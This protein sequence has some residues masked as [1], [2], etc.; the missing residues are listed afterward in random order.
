MRLSRLSV[1]FSVA[2]LVMIA[3]NGSF[4]LLVA[5]SHRLLSQ[6]Q[7]HRQR[8]LTLVQGLREESQMLGRLVALYA[9]T[10]DPRFL[11]YYYDILGIR[12]GE[13]PALPH[14]S[15]MIYWGKVIAGEVEHGLPTDGTFQSLRDRMR[16][17]GLNS[18]EL[19]ALNA[20][21]AANESLKEL[22]QI[23]FAA[24]QGLYDPKAKSFVSDG[25]PDPAFALELINGQTYNKAWLRLSEAIESLLTLVDART[26]DELAHARARLQDWIWASSIGFLLMIVF[27]GF[28][29]R[30]IAT[31]VLRPV[32]GLRT[33]AG[34]L[35]EGH[36]DA[37]AGNLG[38]VEELRV[39]AA[40]LDDM[41]RAISADI[42]HREAVQ[43]ELE[44][45]R[46]KAE[47]ATLA[48]SRFLANMSHEI[49]TPM[50]A[51][52]GML[53][54][55]LGTQ[56]SGQ[57]RDYLT[58][59]Q[60][61]AKSLLGILNDVLD[62]SKVEADR[63]ELDL[64]PFQLEQIVGEALLLVQQR[65]QEKEVELLFDAGGLWLI[66]EG[67]ELV[68][69]ALR[70]R[71]ILANLLSNAVKFT[72]QGHVRL[73]LERRHEDAGQ[74]VIHFAVEDTGIGISDEQQ[75]R[76]FKEFTQA[77]GSTTRKYGGTGLGLV[78]SKRLVELMGGR[79]EVRSLPGRGSTF[80][81]EL[82]FKRPAATPTAA[83]LPPA[84]SSLRALVVDDYP[85]ARAVLT[86][87]LS[88]LSIQRIDQCSNGRC[89]VDH[90][91]DAWAKGT[92][93]D[94]LILDWL[95]PGMDGDA[96]LEALRAR[97]VPA[98]K[99]TIIVSAFDLSGIREHAQDLGAT[100][101]IGKP[102][103]PRALLD[104][105]KEGAKIE[106]R[107]THFSHADPSLDLQG[108]RVLLVEDNSLNQQLA[109]EL[110]RK[111]GVD[112]DVANN[113]AE[114]L[115]RLAMLPP[116]HYAL[117]LMDLQ[118]PVMDGYQATERLRAHPRY[119]HLPIVAM[120]AHAMSD[121]RERGLALGMQGYLAKPFEPEA[122]YAILAE[123]Q[124][125]GADAS[126][127]QAPP[128]PPDRA[129]QSDDLPHIP[130]LD[131]RQGL[132]HVGG[133]RS[134]Y[135]DLLRSFATQHRD[136][137]ARLDGDLDRRDWESMR[138]YV[139]TAKGLAGTLGMDAVAARA[140]ELERAAKAADLRTPTKLRDFIRALEPILRGLRALEPASP[141]APASVSASSGDAAEQIERIRAL[142]AEGDIEATDL[143]Q[144]HSGSIATLLP[145]ATMQR[146]SRAMERFDF[147]NALALLDSLDERT[148]GG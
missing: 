22:E 90:V 87:L 96:V 128:P 101:F 121:E 13:K 135:L 30:I 126:I 79:M 1:V 100:D 29:I 137:Q 67:G 72:D 98:P 35:A 10:G 115:D 71:Q 83:Q 48:K 119:E 44:A 73:V 140:L 45:A 9:N 141:A 132:M 125:A 62:F 3:I 123:Y 21:L 68:G 122:L 55:A 52:I 11:L 107:S 112:V 91:A 116:E 111:R 50:N 25:E 88:Q 80:A 38:G 70:L 4:T 81:F 63:L 117:V 54:L 37:R 113:G 139:H 143:W 57:Q 46:A 102:I 51:V 131:T 43:A 53:H 49:R 86:G 58:K 14:K 12:E 99:A 47:A 106:S 134:L 76:L 105:L 31:H 104:R 19:E 23:A 77:D 59:S 33:T 145:V 41:A 17:L 8:A 89:A 84:L 120:T 94:L 20:V 26:G 42:R 108:M 6:T 60:S 69:D 93:Y 18:T 138:R 75:A 95:M 32:K 36:Y 124:V 97:G 34:Q 85:A 2:L 82:A 24:T 64:A 148:K 136:A 66:R 133:N 109:S 39:L 78:I 130:G 114:A 103:M 110:M 146:I 74:V 27:V 15:P 127:P 92:P 147:D 142:L 28:G 5:Q 144:A 65:A 61:A 129:S 40:I 56:L 118:M 16:S 7:E